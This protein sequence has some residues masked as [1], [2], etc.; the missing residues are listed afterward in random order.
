MLKFD[1]QMHDLFYK[2]SQINVLVRKETMKLLLQ[3][4]TLAL[5]RLPGASKIFRRKFQKVQIYLPNQ[6]S[7]NLIIK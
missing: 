5:A 1:A 6:A 2:H 7:K 4:S 3:G